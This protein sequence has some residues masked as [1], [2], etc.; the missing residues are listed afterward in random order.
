MGM[1]RKI[2]AQKFRTDMQHELATGIFAL[3]ALLSSRSFFS[4]LLK[5]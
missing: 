1:Q 5:S 3:D 2:E 4:V